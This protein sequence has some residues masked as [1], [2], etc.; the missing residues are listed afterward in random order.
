MVDESAVNGLM[1]LWIYQHFLLSKIS[2]P[3]MIY[4]FSLS[5]C[6]KIGVKNHNQIEEMGWDICKS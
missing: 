5:F 4:N 1:K 6:K 3:F 2:W